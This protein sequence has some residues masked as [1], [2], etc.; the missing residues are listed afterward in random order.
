M[1]ARASAH[2]GDSS[3]FR[4]NTLPAVRSAIA[5][6]AEIVEIDVRLTAD[7]EVVVL[8][9]PTLERLWGD[10]RGIHEVRAAE[11]AAFGGPD[12]RPPLLA[13][14]LPLFDGGESRLVIDMDDARF[15]AP[16]HAVASA[17]AAATSTSVD[18]CGDLDGMRVLRALDASARI[19]LPWRMLRVPT[20]AEL[21]ELDPVTVNVPFRIAGEAFVRGVHDLGLTVTAWTVDEPADLACALDAGVDTITTNRLDRLLTMRAGM[22]AL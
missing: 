6:G 19:W 12:E 20:T 14:V 8:H 21:A 11:L 7:G 2:R 1:I 18:W 17:F 16:A 3:V 5:K 13:D 9:D 4:E 22:V 10:P 15:A